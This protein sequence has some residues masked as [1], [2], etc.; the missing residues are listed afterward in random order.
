MEKIRM[1]LGKVEAVKIGKVQ[2]PRKNSRPFLGFANF[3][4]KFIKNFAE[5]S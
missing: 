4:R 5:D 1:D 3:Y 2:P